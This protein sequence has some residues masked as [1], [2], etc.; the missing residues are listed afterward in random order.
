MCVG[1]YIHI[2]VTLCVC[3]YTH[4]HIYIHTHTHTLMSYLANISGKIIKF[5]SF[6]ARA[7]GELGSTNVAHPVLSNSQRLFSY[8]ST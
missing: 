1:I 4:T 2:R 3:I 7:H 5:G 6:A 8:L